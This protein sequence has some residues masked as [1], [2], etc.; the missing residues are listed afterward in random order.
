MEFSYATTTS[1]S[2]WAEWTTRNVEVADG[3][4]SLAQTTA[5]RES[6]LGTSIVDL[7]VDPTGLLYTL[8]PSGALYR[9]DPTTDTRQRLLDSDELSIESPRAVCAS[10]NRV[11]VVDDA[12]GTIVT[13]SPRLRRE[14]GTLRSR[15]AEPIELTYDG[16]TIYALDGDERIVCIGD[17]ELSIDQW[18]LQSPV[19]ITVADD[20]VYVLDIVNEAPTVRVFGDERE[21]RDDT[22]P[23]PTDAF[24]A[25][26]EAF[27]PTAVTAPQGTIVLAGTIEERNE[28]GLFELDPDT[29]EFHRVH[30]L[31]DGCDHLVSRSTGNE[32]GDGRVFYALGC[33]DRTCYALREVT[34]YA[35]HPDRDR[36]VGLAVHRYDSGIDGV[37]W[38]RLALDL[39]RSGASTQVRVR[40]YATD[41]SALLP[42]DS[43]GP[44]DNADNATDT[45]ETADGTETGHT[46]TA[47]LDSDAIE[48]LHEADVDS[49]WELATTDADRVATR[50]DRL[51][52]DQVRSWQRTAG[53]AL[54]DHVE[55][56]WAHVDEI[57]PQDILLRDATGRYLYVA[58]E[59]VGSPTAAPLIDSVTAYCPRRSYLRYLPELYRENDRSAAFLERFLSVF[60][61]SFVD[62][63]SEIEHIGRY[64]DPHGVPS[65]SLAW[66]EDWLAADA[67]RDWPESARREYL[68]R[69][70]ELY[71]K[72]GTRAGLRATLELYLR[73]AT[74]DR[75]EPAT[76]AGAA[77]D[78]QRPVTSGATTADGTTSRVAR[79]GDD[80]AAGDIGTGHRLF[81]LDPADLDRTDG[82]SA[83]QEYASMLSGDRSFVLFCGPFESDTQ[84][85]AVE[86]IIE[87]EKPAH[88]DAHVLALE[89][90]FTLRGDT[91]LGLNTRLQ[92]RTFAMGEAALGE[93]T[94]LGTRESD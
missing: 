48:T 7:A 12:D 53:D 61:T 70:P 52:P 75:T 79:D 69:A 47:I 49:I 68:A 71:A 54:V 76:E 51:T 32:A 38:H 1:E 8:D 45:D 78:R 87:T 28:H 56:N 62:I 94:V 73:H 92:T 26:G 4:I 86:E 93:D 41:E 82:E 23:L 72:R 24:V 65:E 29:G 84:R 14:T 63:E 34:E 11:F 15:A 30:E 18:R 19:D 39:A 10:E 80:Q 67:Y 5:I 27:V 66:L 6:S 85:A 90:E 83:R 22:Y 43:G 74:P 57:D 44:S 37:E 50:S 25:D 9:Y 46:P 13:V 91:F 33:E 55:S 88:V 31:E 40:Y 3:G 77:T 42:F 64:F 58:I 89:D 21:R 2:D 60:E 59:L 16:G 20:L 81:F 17:D 36:H 35:R